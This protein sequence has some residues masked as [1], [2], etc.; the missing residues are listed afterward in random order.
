MRFLRLIF[1]PA[2]LFA[3]TMDPAEILD[4]IDDNVL[5]RNRVVTTRM[6]VHTPRASRTMISKSWVQGTE[7]SFTEYLEPAR[8]RGIKMLKLKDELWTYYPE[9]D[10]TIRIAGH[11][12]RNSMMGSDLSYEDML[13][14]A[15]LAQ[16]YEAT[17]AGNDTLNGQKCWILQLDAREKGVAYPKRK[18]WVEKDKF[19]MLR[20]ER[21]ARSGKL[22]KRTDVLEIKKLDGRWYPV[23]I[24]FKDVNKSG[25]GTDFRI[26][27]I[28]FD[29]EI[30]ESRFSKA[31]LKR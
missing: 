14:D 21:Y 7:R 28:A 18:V 13:E 12:L 19:I 5:S 22:L 20:E 17:I 11:M 16:M 6:T 24:R 4:R 1:L 3:Q 29:L 26:D 25:E 27:E 23:H 8:E 31:A 9:T 10:R 30:P 15:S 2:L